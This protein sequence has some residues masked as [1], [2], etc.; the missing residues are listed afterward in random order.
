MTL[1]RGLSGAIGQTY[2]S[3]LAVRTLPLENVR[4]IGPVLV[5]AIAAP[6]DVRVLKVVVARQGGSANHYL[7]VAIYVSDLSALHGDWVW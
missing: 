1:Q 5:S 4:P 2:R 7:I 6:Q 3:T